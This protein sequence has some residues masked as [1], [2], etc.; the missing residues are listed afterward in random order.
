M[1]ILTA[2]WARRSRTCT[3]MYRHRRHSDTHRCKRYFVC[4]YTVLRRDSCHL[5]SAESDRAAYTHRRCEGRSQT[6]QR[7]TTKLTQCAL[8]HL[9]SCSIM[10]CPCAN[11]AKP[12]R[13]HTRSRIAKQRCWRKP[14][15]TEHRSRT[16]ALGNS[17]TTTAGKV[18]MSICQLIILASASCCDRIE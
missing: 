13:K 10:Y 14:K 8:T 12:R 15:I 16:S 3:A 18:Q 1:R 4:R 6:M 2:S 11:T 9:Y 17:S 5:V 7:R